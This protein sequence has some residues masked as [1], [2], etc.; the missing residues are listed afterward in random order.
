[1]TQR[2]ASP[3]SPFTRTILR[4]GAASLTLQQFSFHKDAGS[5]QNLGANPFKGQIK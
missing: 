3:L 2:I 1:L 5:Q 4:I